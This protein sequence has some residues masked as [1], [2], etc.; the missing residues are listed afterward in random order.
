MDLDLQA[1]V[2]WFLDIDGTISPYGRTTPWKGPRLYGGPSDSD[3][4]VP[5]RARLIKSIQRLHDSGRVEVVWLTTW[6][7]EAIDSWTKV[8]L[9]PFPIIR[10]HKAGRDRWWKADAVQT[11]MRKHPRRRVVW[12]DDDITKSGVR[13]LDK[14]R[15][16]WIAPHPAAGLT[17]RHIARIQAWVDP[18]GE[19]LR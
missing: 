2:R 3:L 6:D 18:E 16:L 19:A 12:T 15:L 5:Y 10:R 9:G 17:D 8:G 7:V 4:A 1:P 13:G 14:Q 11:W